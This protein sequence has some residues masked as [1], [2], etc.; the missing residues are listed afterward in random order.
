MSN[1]KHILL[2]ELAKSCPD[3][4]I[5]IKCSD[6]L[7][8]FRCIIE[9]SKIQSDAISKEEY[10]ETYLTEK[11]VI[12][13]LHTSHATLYRWNLTKYLTYNKIGRKNVYKKS[14][15]EALRNK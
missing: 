5:S 9:E 14:Q 6:L 10:V 4:T 13:L 3:L 12:E 1:E 8:A 15:V 2:I 11:E 7:D